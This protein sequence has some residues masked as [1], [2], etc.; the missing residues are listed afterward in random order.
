VAVP[1]LP[2][3]SIKTAV[4]PESFTEDFADKAAVVQL[5]TTNVSANH[6][7]V[8]GRR[9]TK[10]GIK[11]HTRISDASGIVRERTKAHGGVAASSGAV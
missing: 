11:A 5:L 4:P 9:D 8:I 3:E 10:T 1:S 7:N 2:F 6:N